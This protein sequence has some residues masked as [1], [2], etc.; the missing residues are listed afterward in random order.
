MKHDGGEK[1]ESNNNNNG[2]KNNGASKDNNNEKSLTSSDYAMMEKIK[3][4]LGHVV[5]QDT[6]IIHS[7]IGSN[8]TNKKKSIVIKEGTK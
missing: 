6:N 8:I 3:T 5:L 4:S 1:K 2:N 7:S